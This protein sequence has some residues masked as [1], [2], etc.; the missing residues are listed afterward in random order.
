MKAADAR[1]LTFEHSGRMK[2]IYDSIE[3][4]AKN[5]NSEVYLMTDEVSKS[6]MELLRSNGFYADYE[7]QE[8]DGGQLVSIKWL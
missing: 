8:T 6:E 7:I 1:K 5:G 3:K 2:R 4:S